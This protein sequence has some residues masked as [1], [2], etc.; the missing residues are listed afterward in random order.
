MR[1]AASAAGGA[2]RVGFRV[3]QAGEQVVGVVALDDQVAGFGEAVGVFERGEERGHPFGGGRVE[4]PGG[5]TN[6]DG[7][8]PGYAF[9]EALL[10]PLG[11]APLQPLGAARPKPRVVGMPSVATHL[12]VVV[13]RGAFLLA[14]PPT[15]PRQVG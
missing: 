13:G 3:T 6:E 4:L 10:Q 1:R 11:A 8:F 2:E 14:E 7:S 9:A 5:E 12:G 15:N